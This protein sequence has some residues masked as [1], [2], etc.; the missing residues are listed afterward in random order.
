MLTKECTER[1]YQDFQRVSSVMKSDT[2]AYSEEI[3]RFFDPTDDQSRNDLANSSGAIYLAELADFMTSS[4]YPADGSW[5]EAQIHPQAP[6]EIMQPLMGVTELMRMEL[7]KSNFYG[8][9]NQLITNGLLYNKGLVSVEYSGGLNFCVYEPKNTW[10]SE[11][12]DEWASRTYSTKKVKSS[13]LENLYKNAPEV[14][15]DELD[16][17]IDKEYEIIYCIVPNKPLWTEG[18]KVSPEHKFVRLELLKDMSTPDVVTVLEPKTG[19]SNSGYS[20]PPMLQFR[21]GHKQSLCK[22]ALP[23]AVIVN[24]YEQAML[25]RSEM[26]NFPPMASP[27]SLEGRGTFDLKPGDVVPLKPNEQPPTPIVTTLDLNISEHTIARKEARL[28]EIFKVD[29]VR[30]AMMTGVSQYEHHAMKYSALKAIQPLACLLTG[31]TTEALLSRVH[32]LLMENNKMYADLL[33]QVPAE[34]QGSF[35]FD[36]LARMMQKSNRLANLGRA[37]QAIQAYGSFDPQAIQVVSAEGAITQALIDSDL[38]HLVKPQQ[39]VQAERE[40]FAQAAQQEQAQ[41]QQ[42]EQNKLAPA[43]QANDLKAAELGLQAEKEAADEDL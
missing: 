34:M 5:L 33:T 29:L 42:M 24:R 38:P 37:A 12:T 41:A 35:Y 7:S 28:R 18:L 31:R 19:M 11:N 36:N 3:Q 26:A 25:E 27:A 9:M 10:M 32:R 39:E 16:V 30:Q 1:I 4:L 6:V 20:Q 13:D 23:D 21:T 17:A 40:G 43:L 8:K 22:R 15:K 2:V 14:A